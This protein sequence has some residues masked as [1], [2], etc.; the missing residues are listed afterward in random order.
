MDIICKKNLLA[1]Y[2]KQ[3]FNETFMLINYILLARVTILY[4]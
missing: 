1:I 2:K 3:I 4:S